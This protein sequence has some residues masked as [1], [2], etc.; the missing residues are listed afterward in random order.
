MPRSG[1]TRKV[2][3]FRSSACCE[4]RAR[5]NSLCSTSFDKASNGPP[6]VWEGADSDDPNYKP[7]SIDT[8]FDRLRMASH[9]L[10]PR[11]TKEEKTGISR[12]VEYLAV[13]VK[14]YHPAKGFKQ[15]VLADLGNLL[16]LLRDDRATFES[17]T[18]WVH[19]QYD[20]D[21]ALGEILQ[22][23]ETCGVR[24]WACK[25]HV[26]VAS[27]RADSR[28][29]IRACY[30]SCR[31]GRRIQ[32]IIKA[33]LSDTVASR[34]ASELSIPIATSSLTSLAL[35]GD[36]SSLY[37]PF[38]LSLFYTFDNLAASTVSR[39]ERNGVKLSD[40]WY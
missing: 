31:P 40:D 23:E 30:S 6:H 21:S 11:S 24:A 26:A 14:T 37:V 10:Y 9:K 12:L 1:G 27:G 34:T 39:P 4:G 38:E 7:R 3:P 32:R 20:N 33:T 13:C 25:M 36:S 22:F 18:Q 16:T 35:A 17:F 29:P 15:Q 2:C 19:D 8:I 5:A 28:I